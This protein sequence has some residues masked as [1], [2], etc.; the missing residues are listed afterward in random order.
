MVFGDGHFVQ[1]SNYPL[2]YIRLNFELEDGLPIPEHLRVQVYWIFEKRN[3]PLLDRPPSRN[4]IPLTDL[5]NAINQLDIEG[6]R[7]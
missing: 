1:Y 4:A 6:P 5:T 7:T 3:S 2:G